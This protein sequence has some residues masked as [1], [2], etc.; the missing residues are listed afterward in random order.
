MDY[1]NIIRIVERQ[2]AEDGVILSAMITPE[3]NKISI[4][5]RDPI[6]V[7]VLGVEVKQYPCLS[8]EG[9]FCGYY[10]VYCGLCFDRNAYDSMNNREYFIQYF[11]YMVQELPKERFKVSF[12]SLSDDEINLLIKRFDKT[13]SI[14]FPLTSL[15]YLDDTCN[16]DF[17]INLRNVKDGSFTFILNTSL[18]IYGS[19]WI[20]VKAEIKRNKIVSLSYSE[21]IGHDVTRSPMIGL[22]I[23]KINN[24]LSA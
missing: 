13:K 16:E 21:S 20:A 22:L 1:T 9:D 3:G 11:H 14:F 4:L 18:G 15:G 8:Q 23:Q 12:G 10:A 6:R 7:E 5:V 24:I 19:H 17:I 2:K